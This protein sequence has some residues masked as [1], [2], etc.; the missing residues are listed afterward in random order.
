MACLD[1]TF[2]ADWIRGKADA[3]QKMLVFRKSGELIATTIINV[4]ELYEGAWIHKRVS[5]KVAEIDKLIH[6]LI[7]LDLSPMAAREFGRLKAELRRRGE[8]IA[9]WDLLIGSIALAYGENRIVTR[10]VKDF[11]KIPGIEVVSY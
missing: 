1:T 8:T 11:E 9:D 2:L 3:A 10:N 7:I 6:E 4:V 5:E